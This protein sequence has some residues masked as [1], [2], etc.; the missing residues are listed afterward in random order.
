MKT[1]HQ[2]QDK[3]TA[4]RHNP[5]EYHD[6]TGHQG[7]ARNR[8]GYKKAFNTASR[9][10]IKL[11]VTQ[12]EN[13]FDTKVHVSTTIGEFVKPNGQTYKRKHYHQ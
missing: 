8:K 12:D 10:Y 9:R 1:N 3:D 2:R 4:H 5:W 11:V 6:S 7:A 13:E